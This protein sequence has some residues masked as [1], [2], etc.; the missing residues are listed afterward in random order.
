MR[1]RAPHR[2]RWRC[3]GPVRSRAGERGPTGR[4]P[5]RNTS[6]GRGSDAFDAYDVAE[7]LLC[8][9]LRVIGFREHLREERQQHPV[10][11]L[12]TPHL[13]VSPRRH[14]VVATSS[15]SHCIFVHRRRTSSTPRATPLDSLH[16]SLHQ[17]LRHVLYITRYTSRYATSSTSRAM[18]LDSFVTP[19]ATPS[20]SQR[21]TGR[22]T[23][24]PTWK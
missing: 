9:Q 21:D 13:Q 1:G 5:C 20:S 24:R 16:Q 18:P 7:L 15:R 11:A 4:R 22:Y 12:V 14:T 10:I 23:T 19:V 2:S 8:A 17:S 3:T 6:G